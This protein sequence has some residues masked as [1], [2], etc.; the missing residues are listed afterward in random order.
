MYWSRGVFSL[1]DLDP[2]V[3]RPS[4]S[5]LQSMRHPDDRIS[6]E[7]A[8]AN[9]AAAKP[10]RRT[11]RVIR[12]DG[13]M[14][15]LSEYIEFLYDAEGNPE[16]ALGF[17][18]DVTEEWDL[19]EQQKLFEYRFIA[20]GKHPDM[21]LH[22]VRP[23]GYVTGLLGEI[24]DREDE[25]KR[26]L[27]FSWR[28]L[29]HPDDLPGTLAAFQ[30][31]L[32]EKQSVVREHRVKKCGG[33]YRWRR[34][35]WT[36]V[37]DEKNN[38]IEFL[39]ISLDIENEKSLP[40]A[41]EPACLITG[42]QIRAA[43]AISRWSVQELSNASG[44]SPSIIRRIEEFDGKTKGIESALIAIKEALGQAGI[45]FFFT[46]AGKPGVRPV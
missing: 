31:A 23:D 1:L 35:T 9:I 17:L 13:T 44:V 10:I 37:F 19:R 21:I 18:R 6:L 3:D 46:A 11:F 30:Q 45:Q 2:T 33:D 7:Q 24:E 40:A 39:S 8:N 25:I 5:L 15:I 36:P 32:G 26:R 16:S 14:R 41:E 29:I 27:G 4:H 34:S 22:I 38:V 43:R 28:D 20:A 12:R 42:A